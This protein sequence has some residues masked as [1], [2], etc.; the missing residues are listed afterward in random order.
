MEG[1]AL[2]EKEKDSIMTLVRSI[3]DEKFGSQNE[4]MVDLKGEVAAPEEFDFAEELLARDIESESVS[5]L[6]KKMLLND[7][8]K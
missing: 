8:E 2:W 1:W 4:T 6:Y 3:V 7:I 5:A